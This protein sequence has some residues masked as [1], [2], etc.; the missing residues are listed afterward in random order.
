MLR[1]SATADASQDAQEAN[2]RLGMAADEGQAEWAGTAP[3][4]D[5]E[6]AVPGN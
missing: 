3:G 2:P 6:T 5:L 4:P 1:P